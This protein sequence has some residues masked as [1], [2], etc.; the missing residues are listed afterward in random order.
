MPNNPTPA[1]VSEFTNWISNDWKTQTASEAAKTTY[2]TGTGLLYDGFEKAVTKS[3]GWVPPFGTAATAA[4]AAKLGGNVMKAT[5]IVLG[6]TLD[7]GEG[8]S[9]A[10]QGKT[11]DAWCKVASAAGGV[12]GGLAGGTIGGP[13]LA[14]VFG[15]GGSKGAEYLC[16]KAFD[17]PIDT[18]AT[19]S[20]TPSTLPT[21]EPLPTA[22]TP[23]D[24]AKNL[25]KFRSSV[26]YSGGDGA[27]TVSKGQTLTAI[28]RANG[29][30]VKELVDSNPQ[31]TDANSIRTGQVIRLPENASGYKAISGQPVG[32]T[33]SGLPDDVAQE[34]ALA[35][36]ITGKEG[37]V[38]LVLENSGRIVVQD[39]A[40]GQT[41]IVAQDGSVST[42]TS[43]AYWS[44][45]QTSYDQQVAA[46]MD[47]GDDLLAY[48]DYATG[49][50][51]IFNDAGGGVLFDAQHTVAITDDGMTWLYDSAVGKTQGWRVDTDGNLVGTQNGTFDDSG[52]LIDSV[53]RTDTDNDGT[54]DQT[55]ATTY[56]Y[57]DNSADYQTSSTV[58]DADGKVV[59]SVTTEVSYNDA[60]EATRAEFVSDSSG[61]TKTVYDD[62]GAVVSE[63][64][65]QSGADNIGSAVGTATSF[66]SLI[67]AIESGKPLPIVVS[68]VNTLAAMQQ[69]TTGSVNTTLS[70]AQSVLGAATSLYN[71]SAAWKQNDA[72]G[73]FAAGASSLYY[74]GTAYAN[75]LGYNNVGAAVADGAISAG[76]AEAIGA[77]GA[78]MPYLNLVNDL[79]HGNT[80][81][82]VLDVVC[83]AFPA[84]APFVM[85][86]S[87]IFSMFKSPPTPWGNGKFTFNEDGT[88]RIQATGGDGGYEPVYNTL[89]AYQSNLQSIVV[90]YN[91][92]AP[93]AQIG[94]VAN[95]MGSLSYD[96]GRWTL[97]TINP[98]TG[99][100]I[101]LHYGSDGKVQDAAVG[102]PEYFRSMGEEYVYSALQ[103]G[104][105]AAG[106]EVQTAANEMDWR[107]VA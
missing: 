26:D 27:Y 8:A 39:K 79:A 53:L 56:T 37:D 78:A 69:A 1:S 88:I 29:I 66:L 63:V 96:G 71:L 80:T 50:G 46:G 28:A 3:T 70:G 20:T 44:A 38:N 72:T 25:I 103:S 36:L 10:S 58:T 93:Q 87:M 6:V 67:K 95:R 40:T 105:I 31:I 14:A 5:G 32:T 51:G 17:L 104:A 15:Y 2:G 18:G 106:W 97:N 89:A 62:A 100:Q 7:L 94:L 73:V 13:G 22:G 45:Q 49:Q 42:T 48:Q 60:G 68:G 107:D 84:A 23:A 19:G 16:R 4:D 54:I 98:D 82:V 90:Q 91:Q 75:M 102:S 12:T 101:T 74:G 57:S 86:A 61:T 85:V 83:L 47:Y 43:Q 64:R 55:T 99:A 77:A 92:A 65:V 41:S 76:A 30:T 34:S 52:K 24:M 9:L 81:G 33:S 59:K 11:N 35:Q 21:P